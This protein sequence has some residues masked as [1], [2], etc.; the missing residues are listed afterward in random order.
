MA[1]GF[2]T[3]WATREAPRCEA[4]RMFRSKAWVTGVNSCACHVPVTRSH[5]YKRSVQPEKET[6]S[7]GQGEVLGEWPGGASGSPGKAPPAR[8]HVR[9]WV[10]PFHRSRSPLGDA[11]GTRYWRLKESQRAAGPLLGRGPPQRG[12]SKDSAHLIQG[13]QR[14]SLG[15]TTL[16]SNTKKVTLYGAVQMLWTLKAMAFPWNPHTLNAWR[17]LKST[18]N[19]LTL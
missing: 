5:A 4:G 3:T 7:P 12:P 15:V 6:T 17:K 9:I 8:W 19:H 14:P 16:L 1:G 2:F 11:K 10:K 13:S 18:E